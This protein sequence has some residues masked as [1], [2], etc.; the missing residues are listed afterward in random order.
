[1]TN[2]FPVLTPAEAAA[3]IRNGQTVTL[4][5]FTAAGAP[6][7]I[8]RALA[9]M[10]EAE[11]R[12][13][14]E[15]RIGLAGI[16]TGPSVDGALAKANAVSWRMPF[17][18]NA[19]MRA[20]INAGDT[21]FYDMHVS[22]MTLALRGGLLGPLHWAILEA[23]EVTPSGEVLL[24][25]GVGCT[26]T[27]CDKAERVLI[28]VNRRH[29]AAIR[30]MHDL[31]ELA[32]LPH[33]RE[34][35]IYRPS[36]RIGSPVFQV[37]PAKVAGIVETD[38][39]DEVGAFDDPTPV[40][41]QIGRNV[42]EFLATEIA[43]GRIP[44]TF[45]PVQSG[46][47]DIANAVLGALGSHPGIPAFEMYTEIIQDAVIRLMRAGRCTFASCC[48][49]TVSPGMLRSIYAD[50]DWFRPR[51]LMRPQEITNHPEL[52][53]R[54]GLIA[55]N[56]ALEVDIFGNVNS[57]HLMGRRMM[58]GIG[59]SGDFT[60]NAHIPIFTCPSTAKSGKASTIVPMVSHVDHNEHSV[61]VIATEWGVADVRCLP[62]R[63][64]AERIIRNCVHPDFRDSLLAY[65]RLAPDGHTP[66]SLAAAF[67]LHEQLERTG[68]MRGVDW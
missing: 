42:A 1:M 63:L 67:R 61:Q 57:T 51:L 65:L 24:T 21:L 58:N 41:E 14:R 47:G 34:V 19:E 27:L 66:H 10:A 30:G 6:K 9:S 7:A 38:L 17:Q 4:G 36:D 44:K 40:T 54:L 20:R 16:A 26:P 15:F 60:R 3:M 55:I 5:G 13:G 12:A 33:R 11:H 53:R 31:Y 37:N 52:V 8:P 32:D 64:K 56:T 59:G 62:P 23:T 45:L 25:A 48:A 50:L 29:P 22:H 28:E 18:S 39:D 2:S 49:F 68:D 46:V 43:A 35:P